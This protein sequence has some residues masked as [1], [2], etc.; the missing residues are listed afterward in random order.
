[1]LD[2]VYKGD[3]LFAAMQRVVP[4]PCSWRVDAK[5]FNTGVKVTHIHTETSCAWVTCGTIPT[6]LIGIYY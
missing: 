3:G 4:T 5:H 6:P 2:E 1:M